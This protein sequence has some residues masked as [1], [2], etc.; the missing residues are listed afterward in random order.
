[1]LLCLS[2]WAKSTPSNYQRTGMDTG[3]FG[4]PGYSITEFQMAKA[5][6]MEEAYYDWQSYERLA[7]P[8]VEHPEYRAKGQAAALALHWEEILHE[9]EPLP[10]GV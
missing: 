1:M 7:T 8:N 5:K 9:L 6:R 4:P 3:D 2:P 10:R